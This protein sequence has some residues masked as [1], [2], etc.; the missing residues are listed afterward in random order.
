MGISRRFSRGILALP[1]LQDWGL[2]NLL[3]WGLTF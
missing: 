2:E 3:G 1:D